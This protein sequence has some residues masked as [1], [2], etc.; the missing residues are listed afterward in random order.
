[1]HNFYPYMC[2]WTYVKVSTRCYLGPNAYNC[3]AL[4]SGSDGEGSACN[5]WDPGSIPGSGISPGERNGNPLQYSCLE[6]SNMKSNSQELNYSCATVPWPLGPLYNHEH[7][8]KHQNWNSLMVR[9][10]RLTAFTAQGPGFNP[11][12]GNWDP[13]SHVVQQPYHHHQKKPNIRTE[14]M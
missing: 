11:W 9:W 10:L 4:P 7:K 2:I 12:V 3:G 8:S 6:N 13:T 1:M 5:A 14:I